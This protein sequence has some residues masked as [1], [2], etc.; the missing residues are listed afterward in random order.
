MTALLGLTVMNDANNDQEYSIF[1]DGISVA[2]LETLP[3]AYKLW[4]ASVYVFNI[5]YP[6]QLT[7]TLTFFQKVI[8]N[9]HD[10]LMMNNN[11]AFN[12]FVTFMWECN[13]HVE[14]PNVR[15]EMHALDKSTKKKIVFFFQHIARRH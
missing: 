4:F 1:L 9:I 10:D 14:F 8:M 11:T 12:L 15:V 5:A 3:R 6:K 7:A 2:K 13:L